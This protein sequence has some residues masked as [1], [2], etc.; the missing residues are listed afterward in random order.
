MLD[1]FLALIPEDLL[2]QIVVV[3][4]FILA[5]AVI[6]VWVISYLKQWEIIKDGQDLTQSYGY[7]ESFGFQLLNQKPFYFFS[8]DG[9]IGFSYNDEETSLGNG[10]IYHYG[11]C[12][13]AELNPKPAEDMVSFFAQK[14]GQWYY[15]E[16]GIFE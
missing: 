10:S 11:C 3:I 14:A 7:Q 2:M 13:A 6:V 5:V 12:S 9:E 16:L 4:F 8:R 15:V 1:S